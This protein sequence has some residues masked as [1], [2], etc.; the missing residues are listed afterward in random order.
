MNATELFNQLSFHDSI[1]TKLALDR[2]IGV[3]RLDVE[4]GNYNQLAYDP[5]KD[6]E[7]VPGELS[8]FGVSDDEHRLEG[9]LKILGDQVDGEIIN[10]E[11]KPAI[12]GSSSVKLVVLVTDYISDKEET[13]VI[14]FRAN[15]AMWKPNRDS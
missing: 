4:L 8:F 13:H 9:G 5:A 7:V 15:E 11:V 1:I 10:V 12:D 3:L 2:D 6:P 14:K